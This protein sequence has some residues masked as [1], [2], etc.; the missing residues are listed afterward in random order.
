MTVG[1]PPGVPGGAMTGVLTAF[2]LG[3]VKTFWSG[4]GGGLMTP[5]ERESSWLKD[6]PRV[7]VSAP[8]E[9]PP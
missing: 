5:R 9:P 6:F 1:L 3:G 4:V 8:A 2:S 7:E